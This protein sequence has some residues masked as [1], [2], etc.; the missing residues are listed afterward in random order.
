VSP[1]QRRPRSERLAVGVLASGRGSNVQALLDAC[2]VPDFPARV[3]VVISDRE[4]A[5]A[6]ERARAADVEAVWINPKDFVSRESFDLALVHE[7]DKRQV[8]LVCHAGFMR[9]L[10]PAYVQAFAGRA[11]NV[12]PSLLPAFPGLHAQRQALEHGVRVSGATV[13]F[14]EEGVDSG[15][16][17][18]Q[19][20]VPVLSGDTEETLAARILVEEHRLYPAAVRLFAENRLEIV[21]RRVVIRDPSKETR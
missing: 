15:P 1:T 3:V 20:A 16:I 2:A 17:V 18:L 7:L 11:L 21:G 8:G 6:L 12:H 14:L 4:Q 5:L 9:I 13:H 19:A 10:S